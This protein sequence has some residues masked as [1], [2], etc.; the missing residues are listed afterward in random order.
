M[1]QLFLLFIR[2]IPFRVSYQM[3]VLEDQQCHSIGEEVKFG[4]ASPILSQQAYYESSSS[5]PGCE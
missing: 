1:N 2:I 3:I 5:N 4:V